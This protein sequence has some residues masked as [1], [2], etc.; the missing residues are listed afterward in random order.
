MAGGE[1]IWELRLG[2]R[3]IIEGEVIIMDL[4][5]VISIILL[6]AVGWLLIKQFVPVKGL[7]ELPDREFAKSMEATPGKQLIDVREP[8]EFQR[9]HII[10]A[11]NIPLSRLSGSLN[12][13]PEGKALYLYCQS[14][15]RSKRAA[16]ILL[17][18]GYVQIVHLRGGFSAWSG[19]RSQ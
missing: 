9:G 11:R 12:E 3:S 18:N 7:K 15:I 14:G 13:I 8:H 10:G 17:R 4:S 16:S 2:K 19:Q 1:G 6:L 5:S